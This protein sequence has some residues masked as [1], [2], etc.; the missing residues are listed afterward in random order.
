MMLDNEKYLNRFTTPIADIE[1][2]KYDLSK[3]NINQ[4][5]NLALS[6]L[7]GQSLRHLEVAKLI[8][9]DINSPLSSLVQKK[10]FDSLRDR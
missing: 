6:Q 3:E 4:E 10:L 2:I 5:T 9:H 8:V 7:L 1:G